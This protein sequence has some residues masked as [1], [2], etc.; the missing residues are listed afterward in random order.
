[1]LSTAHKSPLAAR[2]GLFPTHIVVDL[3]D[4]ESIDCD[5]GIV[6]PGRRDFIKVHSPLPLHILDIAT[7]DEYN[8]R[9]PTEGERAAA[10]AGSLF[11]WGI[12]LADP[13][14]YTASGEFIKEST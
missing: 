5:Y 8:T 1:M 11:G 10:K 12:P 4:E 7:A 13:T 3:R 9:V 2:L 6:R 14:R